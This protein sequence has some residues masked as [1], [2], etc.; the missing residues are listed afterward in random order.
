VLDWSAYYRAGEGCEAGSLVAS[1]LARFDAERGAVRAALRPGGRFAGHF[2]GERDRWAEPGRL[3]FHTRTELT[4]L[5]AP[6]ELETWRKVDEDGVALSGPKHWHIHEVIART[7]AARPAPFR[8][9][10]TTPR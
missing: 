5:L 8:M 3:S 9:R 2:L 7:H 1:A 10:G 4:G 6:L